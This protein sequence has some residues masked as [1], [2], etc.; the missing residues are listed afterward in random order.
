MKLISCYITGFGRIEDYKYDFSDGLNAF[1][2][3]NGWGKST[4]CVFLKS[5][6]YGMEYAPRVKNLTERKHYKPWSGATYGGSLVFSVG[7]K[8]YRV[9]RTF[10][11]K[12]K[13]DTYKL[14]DENTGR[15]SD[16]YGE[17]LGEELF[18]VDREAFEKSVFIPQD[19]VETSMTDSLNA[20]I[21][22]LS[23]AKDDMRGFDAAISRIEEAKKVYT[24]ASQINP[25]KLKRIGKQISDAREACD[26]LPV[27]TEAYENRQKLIEDKN[28]RLSELK[29]EKTRLLDLIAKRSKREQDLAL[30]KKYKED[31]HKDQE[32]L[33]R[34]DDFFAAGIPDDESLN[35]IREKQKNMETLRG[36]FEEILRTQPN[37]TDAMRLESLFD[38]REIS[39]EQIDAYAADAER[40]RELRLAAEHNQMPE[41]EKQQLAEL[42]FYFSK[43]MPTTEELESVME[44]SN[45]L[46]RL[47][48]ELAVKEAAVASAQEELDAAGGDKNAAKSAV[49]A[50]LMTLGIVCALAAAMFFFY[51][52]GDNGVIIATVFAAAATI[53]IMTSVI[54]TIH[55]KRVKKLRESAAGDRLLAAEEELAVAKT[56]RH[57]VLQDIRSFLDDYLVRAT[58]SYHQMIQEI[59]NKAVLYQ[60]LL[61]EEKKYV[62]LNSDGTEELSARQLTLYTALSHYAFVYGKDLYTD[63]NEVEMVQDLRRDSAIY[64]VYRKNKELLADVEKQLNELSIEVEEFLNR[65]PGTEDEPVTLELITQ[66]S[67]EYTRLSEHV[68]QLSQEMKNLDISDLPEDAKS[69]EELQQDQAAMDEE[70][71]E[72]SGQLVRDNEDLLRIAQELE[73]CEEEQDRLPSLLEEK[74]RMEEKVECYDEA[75]KYLCQARDQF[76]GRYMGPLRRGLKDYLSRLYSDSDAAIIA[77]NFS[78][79]MDMGIHYTHQGSTK[80]VAYLS[81]G[82]R[83]LAAFCSRMA[84]IDVLYPG[85]KPIAILDDPFTD[86]DEEK[87]SAALDFIRE[88]ARERQLVYFTCHKSRMP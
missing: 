64:G 32:D 76:L 3:D 2:E 86:L 10:G 12:D 71:D 15:Q 31:K 79:D 24:L 8:R 61:E 40:I 7:E 33:A 28:K 82:Y 41:A 51:V 26:L 11:A 80:D 37:R 77:R 70:M 63:Q 65:F 36:R 66:N 5:M 49:P 23:Q 54:N 78:L 50:L 72:I 34:L 85:E 42:S 68:A 74:A 27:R 58:D 46:S 59:Q 16:D 9:E 87:I 67:A 43:K 60:H 1:L 29:N 25:G 62:E 30:Y 4:F 75:I 69:V 47:E 35:D 14:I 18:E 19:M 52:G 38:E 21:G 44:K 6:F 39:E 88:I 13:D 53:F 73:E 20:K 84:L 45:E 48:G 56:A 22:D 83:D 57:E 55:R 17:N 81:Q